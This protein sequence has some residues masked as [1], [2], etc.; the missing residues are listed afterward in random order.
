M[1]P[2]NLKEALALFK[3]L[4]AEAGDNPSD[5][6]LAQIKSAKEH[7]EKFQAEEMKSAERAKE[8]K[9]NQA[10]LDSLKG[11]NPTSTID[12]GE[13][14]SKTEA[15]H[16]TIGDFVVKSGK[17]QILNQVAGA[18]LQYT[19]GEYNA[20]KVKAASDPAKTPANL[21]PGWGTTYERAIVNQRRE[22]LVV[23][24]LMNNLPMTNATI[25]YLVEKTN[26][27]LEGA[28]ATV[29]EGAKKPYLRYADFDIR[30][31]SL[32]KIAGLTKITDEMAEDWDF[33]VAW[34]N[35]NLL[36]DLSVEEENQLLNGDG[37]GN[38]LVGLLN[39][40][41]VQH[42][43]VSD[44]AEL[45]DEIYRARTDISLVTPFAADALVI[46]PKDYEDLVLRKDANNQY[47]AGGPFTGPYGNGGVI[48]NPSLWGM[49]VVETQAVALGKPLVGAF[50]QA[51]SVLR[52]GGVRVDSTNTNV[53]D[54]ENN[55]ITMRAEER[56]GL[57]VTFPEAFVQ[58][59][60]AETT[61]PVTP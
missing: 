19:I 11:S 10:F 57:M 35:N 32:S 44:A 36:Y 3:S 33:V 14:E 40:E 58:L 9:A 22:R 50:R 59:E 37:T 2:K 8:I 4:I 12:D 7:V 20:P 18:R 46:H 16:A 54:F 41:G 23:A 48:A 31:E 6:A 51:A 55:L 52:K 15:K 53:D 21:V 28:F 47:Y 29:A 1:D 13:D 61:E 56:V 49:R 26:R 24:D 25:K 5:D 27:I 34:I 45:A 38:N 60:V 30:T 17:E 43:A 42:R 39:R